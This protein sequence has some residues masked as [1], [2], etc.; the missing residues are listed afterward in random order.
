LKQVEQD[1]LGP[2]QATN[3]AMNEI[4]LRVERT[5]AEATARC[6]AGPLCRS[7]KGGRCS[8][9]RSLSTAR[10]HVG[11]LTTFVVFVILELLS[12]GVTQ[13]AGPIGVG[14]QAQ[15]LNL[16]TTALPG[17]SYRFPTVYV[18]N[19]GK[20]GIVAGFNVEPLDKGADH[21]LPASWISFPTTKILLQ[22][23][24]STHVPVSLRI[25]QG[26]AIGTYLSDV[27]VH[28]VSSGASSGFATQ[29]SAA[30][31]TKIEF[32]ISTKAAHSAGG[33]PTW[34]P[35]VAIALAVLLLL[36]LLWRSGIRITMKK[37][38]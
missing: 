19:N 31:A 38:S 5:P 8:R 33:V 16:A 2:R 7:G 25:P 6:S 26:A 3:T 27:V 11:T 18:I 23:G 14:I 10:I 13:A 17:H 34:V 32:T 15:P 20:R 12:I 36:L 21:I 22:P 37:A 29:V 9:G 24:A 4:A 30:A 1:E 35:P 28:A